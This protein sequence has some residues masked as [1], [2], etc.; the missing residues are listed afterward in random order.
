MFRKYNLVN[1]EYPSAGSLRLFNFDLIFFRRKLH[2]WIFLGVC[3]C[4]ENIVF[5][6]W[7]CVCVQSWV[8]VHV[9]N[10]CTKYE[11]M[12]VCYTS[13]NNYVS[14]C[15]VLLFWKH[16][17][18]KRIEWCLINIVVLSTVGGIWRVHVWG[19]CMDF[20]ENVQNPDENKS[21]NCERRDLW[22]ITH[23]SP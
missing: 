10:M 2:F 17:E 22:Y 4:L 5:F 18:N 20:T 8:R 7:F 12:R 19:S 13:I 1:I 16:I 6:T 3:K 15:S 21:E 14:M 23:V 11:N 9:C